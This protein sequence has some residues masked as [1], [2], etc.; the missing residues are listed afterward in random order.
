MGRLDL[1]DPSRNG[2]AQQLSSIKGNRKGEPPVTKYRQDTNLVDLRYD[3]TETFGVLL[4]VDAIT[5]VERAALGG[6]RVRR[7]GDNLVVE[8]LLEEELFRYRVS[9]SSE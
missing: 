9:F 3:T 5:G 2:R 8:R 7:K 1:Q 6:G 4:S